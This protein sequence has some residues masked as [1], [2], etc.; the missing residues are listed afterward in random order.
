VPKNIQ[1]IERA[2]IPAFAVSATSVIVRGHAFFS[3]SKRPKRTLK[4]QFQQKLDELRNNPTDKVSSAASLGIG[5]S[6][7]LGKGKYVLAGLKLAKLAPLA[8]MVVST[9]AYA[10]FFGWPYACGMVGLIFVHELGHA[11][12]MKFYKVPFSPM[13]FVPFMG[14]VI[15]MQEPPKNVHDE[16]IIALAGPVVGSI[17][18][19]TCASI[20]GLGAMGVV[21]PTSAQLFYALADWGYM[22]NL[23]NLL[24]IGSLDGGR[25]SSAI[26]PW[27]NVAGIGCGGALVYYDMVHNPLFYI[28]LLSGT[29]T[30]GSRLFKHY[31]YGNMDPE[32]PW[33]YF[34]IPTDKKLKITSYYFGLIAL[35]IYGMYEN[36]KSR[37]SPV[38]LDR[39]A[40]GEAMYNDL[41]LQQDSAYRHGVGE[42]RSYQNKE[43]YY[44]QYETTTIVEYYD[45]DEHVE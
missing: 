6:V 39:E 24:P 40:S 21:S 3:E 14:A 17:G 36:N 41:H 32:K 15:A 18:A 26:S 33:G 45:E 7:L 8:S 30:T 4:E 34:N 31:K 9:G 19:L 27:F 42:W 35:L 38:Q 25:I 29:W 20:G 13:V 2:V 43:D 44:Q 16:A 22:I 28:I 12:A 37:K 1:S 10:M 23:F 5:A 11:L